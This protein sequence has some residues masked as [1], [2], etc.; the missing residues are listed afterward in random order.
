MDDGV[1]PVRHRHHCHVRKVGAA[2]NRLQLSVTLSINSRGG[3]CISIS[4]QLG[5]EANI[6]T[7]K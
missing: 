7:V 5:Q 2:N 6:R 3:L 4:K 1:D